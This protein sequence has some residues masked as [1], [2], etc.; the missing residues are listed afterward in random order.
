MEEN[1]RDKSRADMKKFINMRRNQVKQNKEVDGLAST[2]KQ[3]IT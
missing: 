2:L 1:I 3:L